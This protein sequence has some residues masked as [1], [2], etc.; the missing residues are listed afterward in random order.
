MEQLVRS[1][2]EDVLVSL[3][4]LTFRDFGA[5]AAAREFISMMMRLVSRQVRSG[6]E[7]EMLTSIMTELN[8]VSLQDTSLKLELA[9]RQ[10]YYYPKPEEPT[11]TGDIFATTGQQK[12]DDYAVVLTPQ[13]D[14][15]NQKSTHLRVCFGFPLKDELISD[16][17]WPP[18]LR[19]IWLRDFATPGQLTDKKKEE[20][21]VRY[22]TPTSKN[23]PPSRMY[24]LWNF[25]TSS[26][27]SELFG[28]CFDFDTVVSVIPETLRDWTRICRLDSP[29][30]EDMLQKFGSHVY[31][32]GTPQ[33]NSS[34]QDLAKRLT[35]E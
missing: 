31:R 12:Y 3:I 15:A 30:I 16:S 4:K 7:Q 24:R 27:Q 10:M 17:Q 34:P 21:Q 35:E 8:E 20:A 26:E 14:V 25:K 18:Y 29:F 19:D 6:K 1:Q 13:C 32:L 2:V 28:V 9:N 33:I 22:F 5:E 11:W 23:R